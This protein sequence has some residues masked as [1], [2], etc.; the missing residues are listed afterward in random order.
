MAIIFRP[1]WSGHFDRAIGDNK[2]A[3]IYCPYW[4]TLSRVGQ[5][6]KYS[7]G[8]QNKAGFFHVARL[9]L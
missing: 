2:K 1:Y 3:V 5:S 6:G 9:H 7:A 4:S 8:P